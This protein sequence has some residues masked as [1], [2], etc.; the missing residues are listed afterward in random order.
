MASSDTGVEEGGRLTFSRRESFE[1][2]PKKDMGRWGQ[3]LLAALQTL[4]G[5]GGGVCLSVRSGVVVEVQDVWGVCVPSPNQKV[6][7]TIASGMIFW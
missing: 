6:H 5:L 1:G 4:R 3:N 7:L 2:P